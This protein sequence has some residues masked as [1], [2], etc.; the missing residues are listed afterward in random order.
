[1]KEEQDT[2]ETPSSEEIDDKKKEKLKAKEEKDDRKKL[3]K[4][5]KEKEIALRAQVKPIKNRIDNLE[6]TLGNIGE[7]AQYFL[8]REARMFVTS[9]TIHNRIKW[10]KVIIIFGFIASVACQMHLLRR[11]FVKEKLV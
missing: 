6:K 10:L 1:L 2:G 7:S 4:E 3:R 11:F 5:A 9:E 8:D